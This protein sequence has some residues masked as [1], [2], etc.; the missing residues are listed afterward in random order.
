MHLDPVLLKAMGDAQLDELRRD[1]AL[2]RELGPNVA[3]W[4]RMAGRAMLGAGVRLLGEHESRRAF[5]PLADC[6]E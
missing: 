3:W 6:G 5:E 2:R 1:A 4:R